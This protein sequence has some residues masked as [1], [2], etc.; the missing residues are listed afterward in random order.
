MAACLTPEV[1]CRWSCGGCTWA[2][3]LVM[4]PRHM[5]PHSLLPTP[6]D[7]FRHGLLWPRQ[8]GLPGRCSFLHRYG[9]FLAS[10]STWLRRHTEMLSFVVSRLAADPGTAYGEGFL[11]YFPDVADGDQTV[12]AFLEC[13]IYLQAQFV[14]LYTVGH[15]AMPDVMRAIS[16]YMEYGS[17]QACQALA[18]R[19]AQGDLQEL[20][21][22]QV[23]PQICAM[24]GLEVS[25][26][27]SWP[28]L[29]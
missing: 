16:I 18:K 27:P 9:L 25:M 22:A 19:I 6:S 24:Y 15:M 28:L 29:L 26:Q 23:A 10:F 3:L 7:D 17:S 4:R 11:A 13:L 5:Q 1:M 14:A 20:G 12:L 21:S 8:H 2:L